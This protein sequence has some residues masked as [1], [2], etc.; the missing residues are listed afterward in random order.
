MDG[1][2]LC[3]LGA[4]HR[5]G[6]DRRMAACFPSAHEPAVTRLVLVESP[7]LLGLYYPPDCA[8][9]HQP[10]ASGVGG[11]GAGQIRRHRHSCVHYLLDTGRPAG[12]GAWPAA[13]CLALGSGARK[14]TRLRPNLSD[15]GCRVV[16]NKLEKM[17]FA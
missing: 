10:V 3:I 11:A 1:N 13:D 7:I 2:R 15:Q 9:G 14:K 8:G 6:H 12:P 16:S 17:L 4:L 5:L